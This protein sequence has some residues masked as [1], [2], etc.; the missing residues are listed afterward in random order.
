MFGE[1]RLICVSAWEE[2]READ[3]HC[4]SLFIVVLERRIPFCAVTLVV[5]ILAL[6][7]PDATPQ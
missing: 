5:V 2:V 1:C 3:S 4:F 6:A 7:G